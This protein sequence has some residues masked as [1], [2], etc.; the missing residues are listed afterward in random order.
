MMKLRQSLKSSVRAGLNLFIIA[1]LISGCSSSTAP[2]Y[3]ASDL[4]KSIRDICKNEYKIDVVV[5][6]TGRTLWIYIP[7]EDMFVKADKPVKYTDRYEVAENTAEFKNRG[8]E[9]QYTVKGIEEKEKQQDV[10]Y[11]KKVIEKTDNVWKALR[12]VIFSMER[13]KE[14]T[15]PKFFYLVTADIKNGFEASDLFYYLDLKKVSYGFIS[16][17]EFQ[18]RSIQETAIDQKIIGDK[19]GAH[20]NYTDFTM[21]DFIAKQITHRIKLKFQKPEVGKGADIDKEILK[22]AEL[23]IKTY[24]F[25]DFKEIDLY[26]SLTKNRVILN[27]AAV[28]AGVIDEKP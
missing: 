20:L 6:L 19:E 4:E 26:N 22:I 16:A 7:V 2:T 27:R 14:K 11:N 15:E 3:Q 24:N 17:G 21:E 28:L 9:L 8:F 5:K 13:L 10:T 1:L 23:T 12:R 18:H 25:K